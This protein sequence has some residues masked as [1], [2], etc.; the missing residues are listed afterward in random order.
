MLYARFWPR[1][2]AL[3][4]YSDAAPAKPAAKA[5]VSAV[6]TRMVIGSAMPLRFLNDSFIGLLRVSESTNVL[7]EHRRHDLRLLSRRVLRRAAR[8]SR[9]QDEI[10]SANVRQRRWSRDRDV[11]A[12]GV[13]SEPRRGVEGRHDL[14]VGAVL[15]VPPERQP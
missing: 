9:V 4:V 11:G 12:R 1:A 6:M 10:D 2:A 5:A 14:V 8:A 3:V 13:E 15:H 7:E